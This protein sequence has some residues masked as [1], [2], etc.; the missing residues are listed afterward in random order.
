MSRPVIVVVPVEDTPTIRSDRAWWVR[1]RAERMGE[2]VHAICID[3]GVYAGAAPVWHVW[4]PGDDELEGA[5]DV[6]ERYGDELL[7]EVHRNVEEVP[8]HLGVVWSVLDVGTRG[9]G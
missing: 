1:K 2:Y 5:A 8:K 7:E 3:R 4:L 9:I 6:L